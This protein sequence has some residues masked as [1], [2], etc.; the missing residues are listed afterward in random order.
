M[1]D[2]S[3]LIEHSIASDILSQA[4]EDDML[5]RYAPELRGRLRI[6]I[7]L[8]RQ[9]S[10]YVHLIADCVEFC[11]RRQRESNDKKDDIVQQAAQRFFDPSFGK[12]LEEFAE[13]ISRAWIDRNWQAVNELLFYR[14]TPQVRLGTSTICAP[15]VTTRESK[16]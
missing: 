8:R 3:E 7:R 12:E 11:E 2:P 4:L 13:S 9:F 14:K 6:A 1:T 16:P 10:L 15:T 5:A